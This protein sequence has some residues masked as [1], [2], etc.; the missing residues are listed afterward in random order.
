MADEKNVRHRFTVPTVDTV[1]NEWIENQN[2][3]GFSLR[4]LIRAFV[5]QYGVNVDATCIEFGTP[6]PA[7]RGRPPKNRG[8]QLNGMLLS[9]ED[10]DDYMTREV[11]FTSDGMIADAPNTPIAT[12]K[13]VSNVK[14]IGNK[15]GVIVDFETESDAHVTS[16]KSSGS[17]I[18]DMLNI[19]VPTPKS[20]VQKAPVAAVGTT[21]EGDD[22]G[23]I[24]PDD[25]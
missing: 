21:V 19:G 11:S 23:F 5:R 9:D 14:A 12:T 15:G 8:V 10:S 22:D 3:L 7:K 25:L 13:P 2:N 16:D 24:D 1:V 20:T 18:M 6:A 17:T 4:V